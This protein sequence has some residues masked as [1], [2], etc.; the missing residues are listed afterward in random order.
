MLI[1]L[2]LQGAML[3]ERVHRRP[4]N[5]QVL[6]RRDVRAMKPA[7]MGATVLE[8]PHCKHTSVS[9]YHSTEGRQVV[10]HMKLRFGAALQQGACSKSH[11]WTGGGEETD[12]LAAQEH[13]AGC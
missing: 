12:L 1:T 8:A 2:R 9:L 3:H 4:Y 6:T 11:V 10:Q 13:D 5:N 7:L